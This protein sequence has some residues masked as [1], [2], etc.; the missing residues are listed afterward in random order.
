MANIPVIA[1]NICNSAGAKI[2]AGAMKVIATDQRDVPLPYQPS[3]NGQSAIDPA[4]WG[5]SN[6]AL[7]AGCSLPDPSQT[8][9]KGIYY[10][11]V[12]T[13]TEANLSTAYRLV[14]VTANDGNGNFDFG[15]WNPNA[16]N[17]SLPQN[18]VTGPSGP[19]GPQGPPGPSGG[20]AFQLTATATISA[21]TCVSSYG[22][23]VTASSA[24]TAMAG[25]VLGLAT[26]STPAGSLVTVQDSGEITYNGW[27]WAGSSP[28]FLAANGTLTQTVPATGFIQI[29]GIPLS[30]T[31]VLIQMQPAIVLA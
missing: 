30:P 25:T 26:A 1:S 6:G 9:P 7:G 8:N 20:S 13:D 18:Y 11:I 27:A 12:V 2:A 3:S 16:G 17:P 31:T 29:I 4:T 21:Y 5:I 22:G 24:N 28:V 10:R 19:A 23:V 14:A 15:L